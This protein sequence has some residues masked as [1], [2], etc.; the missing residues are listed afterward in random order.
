[1]KAVGRIL[2]LRRGLVYLNGRD[3]HS[4]H[5]REIAQ[6]MA[7]LPQ[8]PTAPGGLT[9]SEL[10]AYGRFPRQKGFGRLSSE[11]KRLVNWAIDITK[12]TELKHREVDTLSGGQRQRVWI[13][14]ALAQQTE[15]ILLD[16]PTTYLDMAHQLEI[17]E[18][19]HNLNRGE[20]STILM[21]LH[22]LNLAARFSDH[23]IAIKNGKIVASGMP[24][25]VV[26]RDVLRKVFNIDAEV[27]T[28]PRSGKPVCLSY[29]ILRA[30][31]SADAAHMGLAI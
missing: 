9:V 20:S 28:E 7:I 22:D 5:T 8:S 1:L 16:E 26:A 2:K 18:L 12:L 23:I 6:S 30:E 31:H 24:E 19:L 21:V 13:A 27:V 29:E 3:I 14:M 15:L 4:L 17:L 25:E 11:D 10:V